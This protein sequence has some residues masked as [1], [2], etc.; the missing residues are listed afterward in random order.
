MLFVK[1]LKK[2][3]EAGQAFFKK[4]LLV[5]LYALFISFPVRHTNNFRFYGRHCFGDL[6]THAMIRKLLYSEFDR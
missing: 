1:F 3:A 5:I 2:N 4:L 6:M